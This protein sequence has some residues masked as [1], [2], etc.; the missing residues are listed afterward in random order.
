VCDLGISWDHNYWPYIHINFIRYYPTN[1]YLRARLGLGK[2]IKTLRRT[3]QTSTPAQHKWRLWQRRE[4][5]DA[6]FKHA[7]ITVH[8]PQWPSQAVPTTGL[9]AVNV[10]EGGVRDPMYPKRTIAVGARGGQHPS[11]LG[12]IQSPSWENSLLRP[13]RVPCGGNITNHILEYSLPSHNP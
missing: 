1:T 13:P 11:S 7:L 4:S 10:L 3:F 8:T 9:I 6:F 12:L 5:T 2:C